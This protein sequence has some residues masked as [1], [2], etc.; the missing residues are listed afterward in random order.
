MYDYGARMYMPDLGRWG[1]LDPR[2]QYTHEAYSYVWNNPISFWDPTGMTGE[3]ATCPTCPNTA[4]FQ[5]YIND[6]NNVYVYEPDTN[7]AVKEI[8]IQEVTLTGKAKSSDSGPGSLA[9]AALFVSQADSPVPGPADVV[10]AAMLIGAGVWWTVNQFTPPSTGYTTIADPGA[11]YRNLKTEDSADEDKDVNGQDVPKEK[12][13][14]VSGK[15]GKEAAKDVPS[16][17][18]EQG[19]APYVDEDGKTFA[20]RLL[21]G[22]YGKGEWNKGKASKGPGS[23]FNKIKKWGDRGFEVKKK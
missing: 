12:K 9:M 5:P 15:T 2:T 18:K 3:L 13:V 22:Q 16:W 21:N 23:E 17:A 20:E 1:V 4:E 6:P 10:A 14:P 7:T 19:E 11:G 8:Q